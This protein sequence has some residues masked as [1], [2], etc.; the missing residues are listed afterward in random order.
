MGTDEKD[1]PILASAA[2]AGAAF[3]V[4]GNVRHFD[5]D[6]L[7]ALG[8]SAV[9]PDLFLTT[10][11]TAEDYLFVLDAIADKRHRD[12]RTPKA[13]HET[14][15][16]ENLPIL[17]GAHRDALGANG[18]PAKPA[19]FQFRGVTC[20]SCATPQHSAENLTGGLCDQCRA[21]S[22]SVT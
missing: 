2:A 14:Q 8:M 3:V 4:T 12:P 15:V 6:D 11:V 10:R 22:V 13:I 7:A 9:H 5:A 21:A 18:E 17:Y 1:K 19:R 20:L 16:A